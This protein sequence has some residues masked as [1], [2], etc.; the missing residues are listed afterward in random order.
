VHPFELTYFNALAGGPLGGRHV[1]ADSNLDWGQ[2]L[3]ALAALQQKEPAF[4][5]LTL[6]YFGDTAPR[7]YGVEGTAYVVDAIESRSALPDIH[8]VTTRFLAVSASL[9]WGPW[10]PSGFFEEL[11]SI[12]PVRMTRDTTIAIYRTEALRPPWRS[13]AAGTQVSRGHVPARADL[14]SHPPARRSSG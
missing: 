13:E 3:K 12:P 14:P 4:R 6:F 5:D 7:Y 8:S 10:G 2:G 11:N 1:L 9:Q